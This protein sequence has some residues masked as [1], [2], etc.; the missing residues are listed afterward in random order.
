MWVVLTVRFPQGICKQ[1]MFCDSGVSECT[2]LGSTLLIFT[3]LYS[4]FMLKTI[5]QDGFINQVMEKKHITLV[6][7]ISHLL[8]TKM[9]VCG[10][11]SLICVKRSMGKSGN[12]ILFCLAYPSSFVFEVLKSPRESLQDPIS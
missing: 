9:F 5:N 2:H 1:E 10:I 11:F 8:C 7:K 4:T 3:S 12:N 6:E